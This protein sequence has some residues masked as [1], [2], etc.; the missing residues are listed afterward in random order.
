[1]LP[2]PSGGLQNQEE[3]SHFG[4]ILGNLAP[5]G[6]LPAAF[7]P[8]KKL[9]YVALFVGVA[10]GGSRQKAKFIYFSTASRSIPQPTRLLRRA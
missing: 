6:S 2:K 10:A 3:I 5:L 8:E 7:T 9:R 4:A 1:M